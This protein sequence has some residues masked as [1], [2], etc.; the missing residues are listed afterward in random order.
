MPI[1][2]RNVVPMGSY[3]FRI[4]EHSSKKYL[5]KIHSERVSNKP[6]PLQRSVFV[7]EIEKILK[8]INNE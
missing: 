6:Y 7:G 4:K 5:Y 2:S 1:F 8:V 3:Y